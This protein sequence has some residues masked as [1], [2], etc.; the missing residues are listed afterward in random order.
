MKLFDQVET[1]DELLE[2]PPGP[3][4]NNI[5]SDSEPQDTYALPITESPSEENLSH[6]E[7]LASE[8]EP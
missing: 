5:Q 7:D 8:T 6:E 1:D 2:N 3:D 4:P